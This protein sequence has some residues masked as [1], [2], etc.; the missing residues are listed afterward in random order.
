[1]GTYDVTVGYP[2]YLGFLWS[3][4]VDIGT[5]RLPAFAKNVLSNCAQLL[6]V[7]SVAHFEGINDRIGGNQ[8]FVLQ[9]RISW[10]GLYYLAQRVEIPHEM[11]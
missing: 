11:P 3:F 5:F 7:F 9:D 8:G 6:D 1:M 10:E 2:D 4:A